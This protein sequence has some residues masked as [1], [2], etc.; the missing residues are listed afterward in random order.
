MLSIKG[1]PPMFANQVKITTVLEKRTKGNS[2]NFEIEPAVGKTFVES[3]LPPGDPLFEAGKQCREMVKS[4][5]AKAAYETQQ[6]G[7]GNSD[8]DHF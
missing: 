5:L 1:K 6:K 8:D 2:Y 3:L 7:E 4:G